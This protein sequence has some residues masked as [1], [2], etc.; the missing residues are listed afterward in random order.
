MA[1]RTEDEIM[2]EIL[3]CYCHLSPENL[4]CD[5]ELSIAQTRR[6]YR[7]LQT[8]LGQLFSELGRT[9]TEGE[10]Y[11]WSDQKRNRV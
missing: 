2:Q 11:A 10:A 5:G 4:S 1:K 6:R 9:V 8:R 3:E 7:Q